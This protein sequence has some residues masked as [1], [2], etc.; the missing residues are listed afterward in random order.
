MGEG[1]RKKEKEKNQRQEF[2][3]FSRR[4]NLEWNQCTVILRILK[5]AFG[6]QDHCVLISYFFFPMYL[7]IYKEES[8]SPHFPRLSSQILF[9]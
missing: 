7:L 5:V 1:G 9:L 4:T 3:R 8:Y 6:T 2:L